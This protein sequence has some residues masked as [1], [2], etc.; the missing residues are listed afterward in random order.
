MEEK[1]MS[2]KFYTKE[3]LG[4]DGIV[5]LIRTWEIEAGEGFFD[6][7][8]FNR[9]IPYELFRN[10]IQ[11]KYPQIYEYIVENANKKH[12]PYV[13]EDMDLCSNYYLNTILDEDNYW[14]DKLYRLGIVPTAEYILTNEDAWKVF[15]DFFTSE[16]E[17]S[18]GT[19]WI[20]C[21][22]IRKYVDTYVYSLPILESELREF[23]KRLDEDKETFANQ[24]FSDVDRNKLSKYD[25]IILLSRYELLPIYTWS[26]IPEW[27]KDYE[28]EKYYTIKYWEYLV[29]E[30]DFKIE[31]EPIGRYTS[32][33]KFTQQ[34]AIDQTYEFI[35]KNRIIGC[36]YD[37]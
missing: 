14:D 30:D 28:F 4:V 32:C 3:E 23:Q 16:D 24:I 19:P 22:D 9:V 1:S 12:E 15:E 10:Y 27:L 20:D 18:D 34:Q 36:V 33:K 6:Y 26:S 17:T 31:G 5:E 7:C 25:A 29:Y 13:N 8:S 2:V 35:K 37:W 21:Y 11:E